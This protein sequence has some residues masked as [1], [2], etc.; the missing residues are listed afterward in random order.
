LKALWVD[1]ARANVRFFDVF[2]RAPT[3]V[4]LHGLGSS[5]TA[6]FSE[7]VALESLGARRSLLIDFLGF[8]YSDKP[9]GFGYRPYDHSEVVA[10]VLR[11][12]AVSS[13]V[14]IGHGMGG[15][16]GIALAKDHPELVSRLVLIE[17][18]LDPGLNGGGSQIVLQTE[19]AFTASGHAEFLSGLESNAHKAPGNAV[20]AGAF[21]VAAPH[22]VHRSAVGLVEGT[23][24]P[25]RLALAGMSIPK[26]Y[27]IGERNLREFN[28]DHLQALGLQVIPVPGSGHS[29]MDDNPEALAEALV[30]AI[31]G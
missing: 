31:E 5:S 23:K 7:M 24:P 26:Y 17:S 22:A 12:Q 21:A 29:M 20:F 15:V 2:Q 14:V 16:V 13:A 10:A 18:N 11:Q 25:Q 1:W 28:I 4:M 27:L 8:G 30:Q 19:A 6:D 9:L 3:L